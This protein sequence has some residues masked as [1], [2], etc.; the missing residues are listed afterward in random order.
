[1]RGVRGLTSSPSTGRPRKR[2]RGSN[3]PGCSHWATPSDESSNDSSQGQRGMDCSPNDSSQEQRREDGSSS[4]SSQE[5]RGE[6]DPSWEGSELQLSFS[7]VG[8]CGLYSNLQYVSV[9]VHSFKAASTPFKNN[10]K[11]KKKIKTCLWRLTQMS[12]RG[13][14]S[15]I[16]QR[17]EFSI[18]FFLC[19]LGVCAVP[20]S[21]SITQPELYFTSIP[22]FFS[23]KILHNQSYN[24]ACHLRPSPTESTC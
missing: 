10:Y 24:N 17:D 1:M 9:N 13:G 20:Y 21:V 22:I 5:C 14:G 2:R 23:C 6:N 4:G 12:M 11:K 19:S 3:E 15:R 8:F 7:Q 16:L 18:D